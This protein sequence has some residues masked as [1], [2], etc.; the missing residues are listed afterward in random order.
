MPR[1]QQG[2]GKKQGKG[3][4][5]KKPSTRRSDRLSAPKKQFAALV[6]KVPTAKGYVDTVIAVPVSWITGSQHGGDLRVW[7]PWESEDSES[8]TSFLTSQEAKDKWPW[9]LDVDVETFN[10]VRIEKI[11]HSCGMSF[12]PPLR[13][14][15]LGA[16]FPFPYFSVIR[17]NKPTKNVTLGR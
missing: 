12:P 11:I 7:L 3:S 2:K 10:P 5:P 15:L 1:G 6:I 4:P 8:S 16:I 17:K 14:T 9:P 13:I